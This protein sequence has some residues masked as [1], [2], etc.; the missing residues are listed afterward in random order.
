VHVEQAPRVALA[1]G[2]GE[3]A[4]ESDEQHHVNVVG[5][6]VGHDLRLEGLRVGGNRRMRRMVRGR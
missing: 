3:D 6:Q 5:R 1:E 2:R 4:H